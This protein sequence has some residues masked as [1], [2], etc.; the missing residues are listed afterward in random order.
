MF[1]LLKVFVVAVGRRRRGRNRGLNL[2]EGHISVVKLEGGERL[3]REGCVIPLAGVRLGDP[4]VE[5]GA[6]VDT[7]VLGA[8]KVEVFGEGEVAH[9]KSVVETLEVVLKL[10]DEGTPGG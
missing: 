6:E 3:L 10:E 9:L 7:L 8:E 5:V 2:D 1:P 4:L